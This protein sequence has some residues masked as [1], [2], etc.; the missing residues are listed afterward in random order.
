MGKVEGGRW[1]GELGRRSLVERQEGVEH[2]RDIGHAHLAGG[3]GAMPDFLEP[4]AGRDQRAGGFTAPALIP[5]SPATEL[6]MGG[7]ALGGLAALIGQDNT[8]ALSGGDQGEQGLSGG[9]GRPGGPSHDP[10]LRL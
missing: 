10:A 2:S 6:E 4:A 9:I 1:G 3:G 8:L 7:V 5:F